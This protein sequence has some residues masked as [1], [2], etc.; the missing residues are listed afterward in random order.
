MINPELT[1]ELAELLAID[2]QE[3]VRLLNRFF[4]AMVSELLAVRKLSV[5]G[6]GAFTVTHF[7]LKKKSNASGVTYIPPSNRL[8]FDSRIS[9]ADDTVRIAV[10]RMMMNLSE[11]ER[12][13]RTLAI[14]FSKAIKQ[15]K[16]LRINGLGRFS[17]AEA[18]YSFIPER[19]LEELLNREYQNL[20]EVM[21]PLH[22]SSQDNKESKNHRVIILSLSALA[23]G[24][25]VLAA[26]NFGK[27]GSRVLI[28]TQQ[29]L[30]SRVTPA[31]HKERVTV[32]DQPAHAVH[33]TGSTADSLVLEKGEYTIVL[34]TFRSER[35]AQNE[36]E[37]LHAEGII[38]YVW[39]VSANAV[40]YYRVMT[41][42]YANRDGAAESLKGMPKK[43]AGSASIQQVS[44]KGVFY[45][46]K[47]L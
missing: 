32:R 15:Q 43:N 34:E 25:L 45:G 35:T 30:E 16:E 44:K 14:V 3:A 42:K 13:G 8:T 37:R 9:G 39:P 5:A 21:L 41:G 40:K 26:L 33:S 10:T 11:A 7:A 24:L 19:S 1:E 2:R 17:L 22:D 4:S 27:F 47:G 28:S 36:L 20:E 46:K 12:L 18:V 6:L 23:L 29:Q 31:V 38:A